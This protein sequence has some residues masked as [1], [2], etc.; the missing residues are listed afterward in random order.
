MDIKSHLPLEEL[1][2]LQRLEK[3]ADRARRI[4]NRHP[5]HGGLDR[6]GGHNGRGIVTAHLPAV[7]RPL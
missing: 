1:K 2:R 6:S 5:R 3:D 7:G 4:A